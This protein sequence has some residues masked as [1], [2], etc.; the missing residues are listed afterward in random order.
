MDIEFNMFD[1]ILF[2]ISHPIFFL[3]NQKPNFLIRVQAYT[4]I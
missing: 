2:S 4:K 3:K 1:E